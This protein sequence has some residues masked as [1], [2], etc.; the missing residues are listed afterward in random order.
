MQGYFNP[1][2]RVGRDPSCFAIHAKPSYFNPRARVGRDCACLHGLNYS[3]RAISF[4]NL[5]F[6]RAVTGIFR[7]KVLCVI[8]VRTEDFAAILAKE[9]PTTASV[10]LQ[11]HNLVLHQ[12]AAFFLR[13]YCPNYRN[14]G[15]P[16][17]GRSK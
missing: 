17:L 7:R 16:F 14:A 10:F 6:D 11:P 13:I 2:A 12:R 5:I 9:M 3:G 15:C 8:R 1:R 4:A